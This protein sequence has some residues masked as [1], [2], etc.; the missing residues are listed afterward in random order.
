MKCT[1]K[2]F[3]PHPLLKPFVEEFTL[4]EI[5]LKTNESIQKLMPHRMQTSIEFFIA[6]PHK[7][8]DLQTGQERKTI[9]STARGF[10]TF[11]K[12]K[13]QI[14]G[15]FLSLTVKFRPSGMFGLLGIPLNYLTD[16]DVSLYDLDILPVKKIEN[17]LQDACTEQEY[18]NIL[19]EHL[20]KLYHRR[21]FKMRL[22]PFLHFKNSNYLHISSIA[23]VLGVSIRQVERIF[24][25]EIG[26][27]YVKWQ[28]LKKFDTAIKHKLNHPNITWTELT[29]TFNYYDQPDFSK[30]FKNFLNISP[31][32]FNPSAFAF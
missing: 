19:N 10:R 8:F 5:K 6:T 29:Y 3:S 27:S 1:V 28:Q 14:N 21:T 7:K 24:L 31:S 4:R 16:E 17:Q 26:L 30:T 32:M 12:Y 20:L 23:N 11:S 2:H 13:I 15:Y 9:S 22:Q 25:K 18:C